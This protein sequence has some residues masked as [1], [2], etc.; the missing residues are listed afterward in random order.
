MGALRFILNLAV[1]GRINDRLAKFPLQGFLT[2]TVAAI[3]LALAQTEYAWD[4][5]N[6]GPSLFP[7]SVQR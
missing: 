4:T 6:E 1:S 7:S 3:A 5:P 2:M